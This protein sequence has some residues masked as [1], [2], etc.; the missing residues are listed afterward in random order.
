MILTILYFLWGNLMSELISLHAISAFLSLFL[1]IIRGYLQLNGQNWRAIKLLK[2]LPHL[3]DTILLVSGL[4]LL[5]SFNIGFPIWLIAK[6]IL[7]FFYI[8]FS[9]KF[10]SRKNIEKKTLY[11]LLGISGLMGALLIGYFR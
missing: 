1:L 8:I 9:A 7:L 6:I 5:F 3:S 2:I 10:F 11:L 4:V